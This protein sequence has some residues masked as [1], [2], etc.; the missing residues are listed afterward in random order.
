M[1]VASVRID[2]VDGRVQE[3]ALEPGSYRIGR[4][5]GA[6]PLLDPIV[7]GRHAELS[8][9]ERGVR[10]VDLGSS[11]GTFDK[12]GQRL[13]AP[14]E[15]A[16]G[17]WVRCGGTRI[18]F[19]GWQQPQPTAAGYSHPNRAVRHSYPFTQRDA[20]V[21]AALQLLLRT[22]PFM[23]ARLGVLVSVSTVSLIFW[24]IVVAGYVFF[25]QRSVVVAWGWLVLMGVLASSLWRTLVRYFLYML[26]LGH[27]AV[28]TELVTRGEVGNGEEGMFAYG[29]RIVQER[30]GEANALFAV[31]LLISGVVN[32]FNRTLDWVSELIP[33]PGLDSVMG[34]VKSV[35]RA[36]T[37]YI[38][39]TIFSYNLARGDSNVLRSSKDGLI[40]YAQNARPILQTGIWVVIIERVLSAITFVIVFVPALGLAYLLPNAWGG[41]LTPTALVAGGMYAAN[42]RDAV[43]KPL[44]LTMVMLKFHA[45]VHDQPIDERWDAQLERASEQFSTLKQRAE[46]WVG[47]P[48]R[49]VA[50]LPT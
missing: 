40:Y 17:D 3:R 45:L 30:F 48:E 19:L 25:A 28:L 46:H 23:L 6:L 41:W 7:S 22:A 1:T 9:G 35:L 47:T 8:I 49:H 4:E 29:K 20:G 14:L 32:A 31:G 27:I 50:A 24:L 16:A 39:E 37:T 15:L 38:D 34:F 42:L 36:S 26:K 21:G 2:Y 44:F 33:L 12:R 18:T 43:L 10:V 5:D 11:N 13:S